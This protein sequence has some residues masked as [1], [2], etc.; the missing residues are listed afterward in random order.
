M[1]N[2]V[3]PPIVAPLMTHTAYIPEKLS[4]VYNRLNCNIDK[5]SEIIINTILMEQ[6]ELIQSLTLLAGKYN[7][8]HKHP[9]FEF[10]GGNLKIFIL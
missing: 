6:K 9:G 10:P 5:L 8:W 7:D 4:K 2:R 3:C 1:S